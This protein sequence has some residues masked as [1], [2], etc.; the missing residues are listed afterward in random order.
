MS[1]INKNKTVVTIQVDKRKAMLS[2][3]FSLAVLYNTKS[4]KVHFTNF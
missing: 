3:H 1:D 4:A 2:T